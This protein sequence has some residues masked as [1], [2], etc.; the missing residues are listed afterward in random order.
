MILGP[1]GYKASRTHRREGKMTSRIR[2]GALVL[3]LCMTAWSCDVLSGHTSSTIE[4]NATRRSL[5]PSTVKRI[6]DICALED[7]WQF[8]PALPND[9]GS[10]K[11]PTTYAMPPETVYRHQLPPGIGYCLTSRLYPHGYYSMN[12]VT[13]SDCPDAAYCISDQCRQQCA[14]DTECP[15]DTRCRGPGRP[16]CQAEP[17][18]SNN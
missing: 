12:C 13:D 14:S 7:G 17:P 15:A 16:F 11:V 9:L 6:G 4:P 10:T 2:A 8:K 3:M 1:R 18:V 5:V